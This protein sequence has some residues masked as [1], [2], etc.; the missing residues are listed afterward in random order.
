MATAKKDYYAILG[1]SKES[2]DDEI[3]KA[4]RKMAVKWHPD[5]NPDNREEAEAKFKEISEAHCI[6][7]DEDKRRQY[8]QYGICDGEQPQFE[9]GFPDLSELFGGMGGMGGM[10]GNM[11]GQNQGQ[12]QRQKPVQEVKVKLTLEELYKGC[13]KTVD[14]QSSN[15]CTDC[16]GTGSSDKKKPIC[17]DCKGKGIKTVVRQ[18]GPGM[19]QQQNMPC[20]SCNQSGYKVDK[21][22]QCLKCTGSGAIKNDVKK[23]ITITKNFDYKTK[24][25]LKNSG[26]FDMN[27]ETNA[28]VFIVFKLE[29][30]DK[31]KLSVVNHYDLLYEYDIH[32]WDAFSGYSMYYNHLDN[33][34]YL[35]KF[36]D[37]IKQDDVK[38]IKNLGL[39][40]NDNKTRGKLIIKFNYIYPPNVMNSEALNNWFKNKNKQVIDSRFEYKKEQVYN[41]SDEQDNQHYNEQQQHHQ[42]QQQATQCQTQ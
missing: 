4:Y 8:D 3:K 34:H 13:E 5:K 11:F 39:P 41:V 21:S 2:T 30:L 9:G 16:N 19:I 14:I 23:K 18:V 10:F 27:T 33:G 37:V 15:K 32:M 26:N 36:E 25:S 6:L 40:Y 29:N 12:G 31:Y 42:Q 35:F 22:K 28:D 7:S 17:N 38:M 1:V 24:M 20:G